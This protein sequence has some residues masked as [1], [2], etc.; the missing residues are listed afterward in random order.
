MLTQGIGDD[1]E[2]DLLDLT[3]TPNKRCIRIHLQHLLGQR[4]IGTLVCRRTQDDRN[5]KDFPEFGVGHDVLLVECRVP[6][7]SKLEKTDLQVENEEQ[8]QGT[9]DEEING[10]SMKA[11]Y[12]VVLV[13]ALP[14]YS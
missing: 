14:W 5:V 3:L 10:E 6:V 4:P 11:I 9:L 8:L 1:E 13:D 7:S 12:R 2:D